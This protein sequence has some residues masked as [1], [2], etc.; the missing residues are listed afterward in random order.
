MAGS[1]NG[2]RS[3][4]PGIL[5]VALIVSSVKYACATRRFSLSDG[6]IRTTH[7]VYPR[8]D[9]RTPVG[10]DGLLLRRG[11]MVYFNGECYGIPIPL[12]T[13]GST[14]LL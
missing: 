6:R 11:E 2:R 4:Q 8:R 5:P 14:L 12:T 9:R 7:C 13:A 3:H 10:L 1:V